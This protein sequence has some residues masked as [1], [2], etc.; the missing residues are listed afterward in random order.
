MC[1][2]KFGHI[3]YTLQYC[4]STH[5]YS[6]DLLAELVYQFQSDSLFHSQ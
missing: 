1:G 2:S 4:I 3:L 5:V 6:I